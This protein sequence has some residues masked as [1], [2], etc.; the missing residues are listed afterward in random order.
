MFST[1]NLDQTLA[2][3]PVVRPMMLG[4]ANAM[5]AS[6]QTGACHHGLWV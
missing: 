1:R 2:G 5:Q 3:Q 6:D 4:M